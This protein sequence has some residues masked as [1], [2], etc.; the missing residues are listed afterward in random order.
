MFCVETA[1]VLL[2]DG[3][4]YCIYCPCWFL[5]PTTL[6]ND[7]WGK[8]AL[9]ISSRSQLSG[10]TNPVTAQKRQIIWRKATQ[11]RVLKATHLFNF[12]LRS[13]SAQREIFLATFSPSFA[14]CCVFCPAH[15]FWPE[16]KLSLSNGFS[17]N[18][19]SIY[20]KRM[21]LVFKAKLN[22]DGPSFLPNISFFFLIAL[23]LNFIFIHWFSKEWQNN[24]KGNTKYSNLTRQTNGC[25][26]T[27][28]MQYKSILKSLYCNTS[29]LLGQIHNFKR[30][31]LVNM[32]LYRL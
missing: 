17:S 25:V 23:C 30:W 3:C 31:H 12:P 26:M 7:M 18:R 1:T 2:R 5:S 28:L 16:S 19:F 8:S 32:I 29:F 10:V 14:L 6:I 13:L 15:Q 11:Q 4:M 27:L 22:V 21:L 20:D 24:I 9:H